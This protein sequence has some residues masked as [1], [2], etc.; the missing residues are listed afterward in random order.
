MGVIDVLMDLKKPG[1]SI[2][3]IF[4]S[5]LEILL[6]EFQLQKKD[7]AKEIGVSAVAITKYTKGLTLPSFEVLV[8]IANYFNVS[9]DYLIGLVNEPVSEPDYV[10]FAPIGKLN[11]SFKISDSETLEGQLDYIFG[12]TVWNMEIPKHET[13]LN[14]FLC[15]K[16]S[17]NADNQRLYDSLFLTDELNVGYF[18]YKMSDQLGLPFMGGYQGVRSKKSQYLANLLV[19]NELGIKPPVG[20]MLLIEP[21]YLATLPIPT[22]NEHVRL[23]YTFTS[24]AMPHLQS[25]LA[26]SAQE[27]R[28]LLMRRLR[29]IKSFD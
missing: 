16:F 18:L 22:A 10:Y 26:M 27:R 2:K 9:T 17:D 7:L 23:N 15:F 25:W 6:D 8:S 29:R 11:Y 4:S 21:Q 28:T 5:R 24:G 3:D 13:A 20:Q 19:W 14:Q 12:L 1:S